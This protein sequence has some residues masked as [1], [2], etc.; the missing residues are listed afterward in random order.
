MNADDRQ[1]AESLVQ[2]HIS[3]LLDHVGIPGLDEATIALTSIAL[4]K[5]GTKLM[6][7]QLRHLLGTTGRRFPD[8]YLAAEAAAHGGLQEAA[9]GL[10]AALAQAGRLVGDA[11][12]F[13]QDLAECLSDDEELSIR[14]ELARVPRIPTRPR[15]LDWSLEPAPWAA[16]NRSNDSPWPPEGF[17]TTAGLRTLPGGAGA[18][19]QVVDGPHAGW[20]QIALAEKHHTP[21]RRY[22]ALPERK[23]LITLGV[24]ITD[25][26]PPAG[27]FPF[28]EG[29]WQL[30]TEPWQDQYLP[31][32]PLAFASRSFRAI[33]I[34]DGGLCGPRQQRN[35]GPGLPEFLLAPGPP[36]IAALNLQP[37]PG[38]FA[39]FSLS[40]N[41]GPGLVGR[42]WRGQLVH[43]GNYKPLTP[44]V[45]GC[46]LLVRPDL[47]A[48]VIDF[49]TANRV[50]AGIQVTHS[51]ETT[52]SD[53]IE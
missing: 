48:K 39:G 46:D 14:T 2:E 21:A 51:A 53:H 27:S 30:W 25:K 15:Q 43:D 50:H 7:A 9:A 40:D 24:E 8:A 34:T 31:A 17:D 13:E 36:L 18:L 4:S 45:E 3:H 52:T 5:G 11:H 26:A 6:R 20:T 49:A 12:G 28:A 29:R 23:V 41:N 32:D 42:Q 10:R 19:A 44:A 37:T 35:N 33:V 22:P 38:P 1:I 16:E 47:L